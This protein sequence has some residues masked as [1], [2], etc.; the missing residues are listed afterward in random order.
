MHSLPAYP[1]GETT[2]T[3]QRSNCC[4][5]AVFLHRHVRWQ[6]AFAPSSFPYLGDTQSCAYSICFF[7]LYSVSWLPARARRSSMKIS[8]NASST[9]R[10]RPTS[11]RTRSEEHTSE[12]QSRPHL[13][14]RLLLEK[15]K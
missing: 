4:C 5:P 13:V 9:N 2:I 15:K 14:C 11:T 6:Q 8:A 1:A 3:G 7:W 10:L 12:L